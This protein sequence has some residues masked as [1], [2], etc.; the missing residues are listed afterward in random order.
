MKCPLPLLSLII[1]LLT[2]SCSFNHMAVS[3]S[4]D[5]LYVISNEA[6]A[7]SNYEI[8]RIGT[9]ANLQLLEGLLS[10]S[11]QNKDLLLALTKGYGGYAFAVNET[12]MLNEEWSGANDY[13]S[14]FARN[15]ALLNYSRSLEFGIRYLHIEKI[16]FK[17]LLTQTNDLQAVT[18]LFNKYLS[19]DKKNLELLLF[20]AQALVA[21]INLQ[22]DNISLV[23]Q[24]PLAKTMF[25][26]VCAKNPNINF[27]NCAILQ[28]ALEASR[29]KMLGGNPLKGKE[30]FLLGIENN[31]H[32]WLIRS[33][34]MQ[35]YLIPQNDKEGFDFQIKYLKEKQQE[36]NSYHIYSADIKNDDK[37]KNELGESHLRFYQSLGLK[38][39]EMMNKYY[40]QFF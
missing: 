35:Y 15:Q 23:A 9:P 30:I 27:G 22:K 28:G 16:E 33:M 3:S 20:T 24:L 29:P 34:Y 18:L 17:K 14:E 7:G 36:F 40:K 8:F 6:E 10:E 31:P 38:R 26:W 12:E 37:N 13:K 4:S 11:P 5:L 19:A 39:T 32:N 21:L 2:S 25:D 1:I